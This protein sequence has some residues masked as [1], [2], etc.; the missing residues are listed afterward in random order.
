MRSITE[1]AYIPLCPQAV[2]VWKN[3][4]SCIHNSVSIF[5]IKLGQSYHVHYDMKLEYRI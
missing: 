2:P 5:S 3:F 1:H 4:H